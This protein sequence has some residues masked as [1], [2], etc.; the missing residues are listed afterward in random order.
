MF[1]LLALFA[2]LVDFVLD[3]F[4]GT[5]DWGDLGLV[6]LAAAIAFGNWPVAMPWH[7]P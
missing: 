7:R 1:A 3:L 6:L 5:F 4:F 2:F